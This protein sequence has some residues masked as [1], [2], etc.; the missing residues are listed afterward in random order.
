MPADPPTKTDLLEFFATFRGDGLGFW[1]AI[2]PADFW[3]RPGGAW[4]PADNVRHLT[5]SA[6]PV[7]R[8][9]RIPRVILRALFGMATRPSRT[10]HAL[11]SAYLDR[12]AKGG[13][14]GPYA[15]PPVAPPADLA[16]GQRRLIGECEATVL[17]LERAITAWGDDALD[18]YRLPHPLIG[19]LTLR[20]ML[21]FTLFH[22]DHHRDNVA[23][24]LA[25][26]EPHR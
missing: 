21:V 11:R 12:L 25:G 13:S 24:R 18:R 7:A 3:T 23:R 14:A 6:A 5:I 10:W 9:L 1:R 22:F 19:K 16:A 4:S 26:Q 8:A 2:D 20:E 17:S 15:P